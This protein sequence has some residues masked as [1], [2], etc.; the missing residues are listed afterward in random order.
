MLFDKTMVLFFG[1]K[2]YQTAGQAT[3]P[4]YRSQWI[5][6]VL[7]WAMKT[8]DKIETAPRQKQLLM[9]NVESAYKSVGNT[10]QHPSWELTYYL[11]ALIGRLQGI[12]YNRGAITHTVSYWQSDSQ[13]Y[14]SAVFEGIKAED[15]Y[16]DEKQD[17]VSIKQHV[18]ESLKQQGMSDFKV[19]LVLNATEYEVQQL[20]R[21]L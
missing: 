16:F 1:D 18:I 7:K 20:P 4:K 12:S 13:R 19:A 6:R 15:G 2:A 11:L 5:K 14:T 9:A 21:G 8:V 17:A 10:D 3:T